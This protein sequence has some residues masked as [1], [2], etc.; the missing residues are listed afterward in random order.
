[1][2]RFEIELEKEKLPFEIGFSG[3]ENGNFALQVTDAELLLLY[4]VLGREA[5]TIEKHS[6]EGADS[7]TLNVAFEVGN[8]K[9]QLTV[10]STEFEV[11]EGKSVA[12]GVLSVSAKPDS[13][14]LRSFRVSGMLEGQVFTHSGAPYFE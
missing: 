13:E 11:L 9:S 8:L 14:T 1:M 4:R 3:D 2:K 12:L 7:E 10:N 5:V 6:L